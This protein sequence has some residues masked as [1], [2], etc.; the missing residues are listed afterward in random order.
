VYVALAGGDPRSAE[1]EEVYDVSA[2]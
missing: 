2:A 1:L